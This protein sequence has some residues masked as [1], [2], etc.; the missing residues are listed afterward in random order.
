MKRYFSLIFILTI[1]WMATKGQA[2]V[3]PVYILGEQIVA[4]TASN[5]VLERET[6]EI[7][8]H[9]LNAEVVCH[10]YLRNTGEKEHLLLA[11]PGKSE[12]DDDRRGDIHADWNMKSFQ[13]QMNHQKVSTTYISN[14]KNYKNG[15]IQAISRFSGWYIWGWTFSPHQLVHI[16]ISYTAFDRSHSYPINPYGHFRYYL[17][18]GS[19]WKGPIGDVQVTVRFAEMN[20]WQVNDFS[21]RQGQVNADQSISWHFT[22]IEPD[23]HSDIKIWYEIDPLAK[24]PGAFDR[25]GVDSLRSQG[26]EKLLMNLNFETL[27]EKIHMFVKRLN[28]ET[29]WGYESIYGVVLSNIERDVLTAGKRFQQQKQWKKAIAFYVGFREKFGDIRSNLRPY[30]IFDIELA[31]CYSAIGDTEKALT[32]YRASMDPAPLDEKRYKWGMFNMFN[33]DS[34]EMLKEVPF[35]SPKSRR[36]KHY[37]YSRG[38]N[39]YCRAR[40]RALGGKI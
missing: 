38:L 8:L 7:T 17:S 35:D 39:E 3:G 28:E 25:L 4:N 37:F 23:L 22:N 14:S 9:P 20:I 18:T 26:M 34:K 32:Y 10:F 1:L 40:I 31:E 33:S 16:Q 24:V 5:V 30:S 15:I 29:G 19:F 36:W 13:V 27:A 12:E 21:P 11:F 2:D 6:V